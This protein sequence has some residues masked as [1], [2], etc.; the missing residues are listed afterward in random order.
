MKLIYLWMKRRIII[1]MMK[2]IMTMKMT[3][4]VGKE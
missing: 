4:K 2:I 1:M 3:M